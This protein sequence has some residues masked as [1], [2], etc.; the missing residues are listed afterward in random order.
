MSDETQWWGQ[1][2]KAQVFHVF[3]GEKRL[4]GSLCGNWHLSYDGDDPEVDPDD[5]EWRDG[6]DCKK[7]A[8]KAGV[9]EE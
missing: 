4:A 5:D 7:C 8:R 6:K 2:L 1:P 3:E 9:L